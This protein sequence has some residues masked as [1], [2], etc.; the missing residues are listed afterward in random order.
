MGARYTSFAVR[1]VCGA[2]WKI[3]WFITL[4][5][6]LWAAGALYFDSPFVSLGAPVAAAFIVALLAIVIFVRSKLGRLLAILACFIIVLAWWFSLVPTNV[7]NWQ[8]DVAQLASAEVNGDKVTLHN[9]RN[10]DY[11]TESDYTPHW[12]TRTVS[13]SRITGVDIAINYWGSKLMAHPILSFQFADAPPVCFSIETRKKIGQSYSAIGGL[14][15]QYELIYVV[16][17]ERDVI[18]VR[19][20]YRHG[21][22]I[23]LYRLKVPSERVRA[24]FLEYVRTL[25]V[26]RDGPRWY[27]AVTD[28]CTTAI[29]QQRTVNER[30]PWDWR[31]LANGYGDELLYERGAIDTSLPFT[32]LKRRS[33]I[34]AR[35]VAADRSLQPDSSGTSQ[36]VLHISMKAIPVLVIL[37]CCLCTIRAAGQDDA[38]E[39]AKKLANPVASLISIPLQSNFDFRIGPDKDGWRYTLNIQ[40]VIPVS[41]NNDWNLIVR[42]IVPVIH[43]EDVFKGAA[44]SFEE[45]I[46]NVPVDLTGDQKATLRSAYDKAVAERLPGHVQDGLGDTVQSFFFSPKAPIGGWILAAGPAFLYPT[47]TDDLLGSQKWGAGPTALALQQNGGW[48]YGMLFNQIWSFAG[49]ESRR[50]VNNTFLQPFIS[51]TTKTKTTFGINAESTYN[52]NDSQWN[53]PLNL[54]ISQLLKVGPLPMQFSV[55]GRYYAD[56][57]VGGPK[58]GVRFVVTLLFP[59]GAKPASAGPSSK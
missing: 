40:P 39:L 27:N 21:E 36:D 58:W 20:N 3:A 23:Y 47:A 26:L 43:Q 8:P 33:L 12:E 42:T 50:N 32:E 6:A 45:L 4:C 11:R 22:D 52:W 29:R 57:P 28:N 38:S 24:A 51:Y 48:T 9:V 41:L 34:N 31:I 10:C 59:T 15:R 49:E 46:D 56:G 14:Y 55:G 53:V 35:A 17:D 13:L 44:P 5:C 37:A 2:L 18:R 54:T 16:A 1:L 25:N 7:A 30:T 19:T